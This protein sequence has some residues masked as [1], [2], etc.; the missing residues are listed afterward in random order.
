MS[1]DFIFALLLL[2][3]GL[4]IVGMGGLLIAHQK[5]YYDPKSNS[6]MSEIDIPILGKLKTNVPAIVICLMGLIPVYFAQSEMK[7][8][9]PT[10]VPFNGEVAIDPHSIGGI[11]ALTVG[12]TSGQW[13]QTTTPDTSAPSMNLT[14]SVPDSWP[15]YTAYAFALGATQTRPAII[16]TS[17]NN[18]KFK[19]RIGP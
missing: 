12:V 11:H 10:L 3:G 15:T 7:S 18:P 8:R 16:G 6:V 14:I 4:A 5:V 9:I 17:L 19:L 2:I 1:Q 13:S